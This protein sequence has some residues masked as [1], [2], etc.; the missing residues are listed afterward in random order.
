MDTRPTTTAPRAD[1]AVRF[2]ISSMLT[3]GVEAAVMRT[4]VEPVEAPSCETCARG[5][6]RPVRRPHAS[7]YEHRRQ[8]PATI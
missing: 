8:V 2:M 6:H 5:A 4:A 7:R 3:F 1:G